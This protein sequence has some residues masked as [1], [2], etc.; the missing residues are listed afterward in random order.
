MLR[1]GIKYEKMPT[2]VSIWDIHVVRTPFK[3]VPKL[4]LT[5]D[6]IEQIHAEAKDRGAGQVWMGDLGFQ[7]LD[8][9]PSQQAYAYV[10]FLR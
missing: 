5:R 8:G 3:P 9:G 4:E 10:A 6:L 2:G 7:S 1:D